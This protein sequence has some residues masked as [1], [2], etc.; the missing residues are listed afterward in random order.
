MVTRKDIE[1]GLR[2]IGLSKGDVVVVHSSLSSFGRVDGG[3]KAVVDAILAV[4]GDEGTLVVPTFTYGQSV[5]DPDESPSLMGAIPEEVRTRPNALRSLHPTHSVA[6]I[7]SLA[8]V[9]TEGHEKVHPFARGSALF[10]VLQARGKILQLGTTH[11]TSSIIHVAEEIAAVPYLDR[12][13]YVEYK[14]PQGK[15]AHKW[16]RR[17]G[18]SRGFDVLEE[19]LQEADAIRETMI[20]ESRVKLM[21]ARA[22]VDA[23]VELLKFDQ[24]GLLCDQPDCEVCAEARA[25]VAATEAEKQDKEITELAEEEERLRRVIETRLSGGELKYFEI[26]DGDHSPN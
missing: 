16:V 12:S 6:A 3:A 26:D 22:V 1:A 2:E 13:R 7:G 20:G 15:S 19:A 9:F 14:T 24:E 18:C 23:A 21:S 5:Y 10:K 17:P 25:M 11:T 8:D 4:I